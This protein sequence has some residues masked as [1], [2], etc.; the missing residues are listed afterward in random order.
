MKGY[1]HNF[2]PVVNLAESKGAVKRH[3][4]ILSILIKTLIGLAS[5]GI[6]YLRLE[7]DLTPERLSMI[8]ASASSL[9]GIGLLALCLVL[10]PLNWGLEARKWQLITAPVEKVSYGT[11][12]KSV[13]SGVCLGNLAPGRATEFVAKIIFFHTIHRPKITV[14]HFIGGM[15]Q[16][17]ITVLAGFAALFYR[18]HDLTASAGWMVY[19]MI[20]VGIL[21]MLS[22]AFAIWKIDY[23]LNVIARKISRD[24]M[25]GTFHYRFSP[26]LLARLFSLSAVRYVVFFVQFLLLLMVF[27]PVPVT[28]AILAGI[29][30]YFL[31][32][33][34]LPMIS[35]LEAA[36]R[37]AIALLV[38]K[39]SGAGNAA[40]ALTSV[41]VWLTNIILPSIVG[42]Y[43]LLRQNFNFKLFRPKHWSSRS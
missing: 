25:A 43:I 31:V 8:S 14:L 39:D 34:T 29:A 37:A 20:I 36:I 23:L 11:A 2:A 7:S 24:P 33:T 1:Q 9:R 10:V 30:L 12:T 27:S 5:F 16:L 41:L 42:Y 32:T 13:Y 18:L 40:L 6:I 28:N 4:K 17:S 35:V 22:L 26:G 15:F 19:A 21:L 3:R 38:F